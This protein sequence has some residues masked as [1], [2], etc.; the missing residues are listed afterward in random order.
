MIPNSTGYSLIMRTSS[1]GGSSYDGGA[2]NYG[3]TVNHSR[4][5]DTT[6]NAGAG[7]I[8]T[9]IYIGQVATG[10]I[11]TGDGG[12]GLNCLM[13]IHKPSRSDFCQFT[14]F[15]TQH[16]PPLGGTANFASSQGMGVRLAS[17]PVNALR[18]SMS[19]AANIN[20]GVFRLYGLKNS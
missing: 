20:S 19:D 3:T 6:N 13:Y 5:T 15:T 9:A 16:I 11:S 1:N 17:S 2:S 12:K 10:N 4:W 7:Q 8:A 18:F 14:M